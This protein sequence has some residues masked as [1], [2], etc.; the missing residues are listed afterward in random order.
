MQL[1][2]KDALGEGDIVVFAPEINEQT[3]SRYFNGELM[4]Q[5]VDS[6]PHMLFR[7]RTDNYTDMAATFCEFVQSKLSYQ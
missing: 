2:S 4:W 3:L 1:F 5:A 7:I 6:N